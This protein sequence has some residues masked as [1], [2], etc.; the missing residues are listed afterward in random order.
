MNESRLRVQKSPSMFGVLA[1]MVAMGRPR[2]RLL[3]KYVGP[4]LHV[5]VQQDQEA[6]QERGE[7][8]GP[9]GLSAVVAAHQVADAQADKDR[10][11]REEHDHQERCFV[12]QRL[13]DEVDNQPDADGDQRR[14]QRLAVLESCRQQ[15][16][17]ER[18]AD[19]G[20]RD[21]HRAQARGFEPLGGGEV[22]QHSG[23][24]QEDDAAGEQPAL[25]LAAD[26]H[27]CQHTEDGADGEGRRYG[28]FGI[29]EEVVE[30]DGAELLQEDRDPEDREGEEQEG[31]ERH[32]VVQRAVLAQGRDDAQ[33]DADQD[34][35]HGGPG[36]QGQGLDQRVPQGVGDGLAGDVPAQVAGV[37]ERDEAP[38]RTAEPLEVPDRS[39]CVQLQQLDARVHQLLF[40][41]G[42]DGAEFLEGIA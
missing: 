18:N 23:G 5:P 27:G 13:D 29:P 34:R 39:G 33:R 25:H 16:H 28:Y 4:R 9:H 35:Q 40:V 8:G 31:H 41:G 22:H 24:E 11:D 20:D 21:D 10:C 42:A 2:T 14:L 36:D 6:D 17:G 15:G 37:G 1:P 38:G 7:R 30:P 12:E 19:A 3:L 26:R 32:A